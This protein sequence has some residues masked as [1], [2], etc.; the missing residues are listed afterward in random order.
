MKYDWNNFQFLHP[1]I[2]WG[3]GLSECAMQ[4]CDLCRSANTY[5]LKAVRVL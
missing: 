3:G 2:E 5:T 1:K 4:G